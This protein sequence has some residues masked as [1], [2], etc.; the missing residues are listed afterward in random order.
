MSLGWGR[1]KNES[2]CIRSLYKENSRDL[3]LALKDKAAT[4]I[5]E[6][7]EV[8]DTKRTAY[9]NGDGV[10]DELILSG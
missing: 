8:M 3:G 9:E 6:W 5:N 10:E 1:E 4:D 7:D 2:M